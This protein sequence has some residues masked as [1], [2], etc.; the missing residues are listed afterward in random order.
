MLLRQNYTLSPLQLLFKLFQPGLLLLHLG[1]FLLVRFTSLLVGRFER[2]N[3]VGFANNVRFFPFDFELANDERDPRMLHQILNSWSPGRLK[4]DH[5]L[6]DLEDFIGV[7]RGDT[8]D[9]T[10]LNLV[11][12][13]D[14]I[15]RLEGR[16][17]GEHLVDHAAGRPDIRLLVVPLLLDLLGAHVVRRADVRVGEDGFVAHDPTQPKITQL[18]VVIGVEEDV[19]G[20]QISMQDL[21]SLFPHVA[22]EQSER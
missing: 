8:I 2:G 5:L 10:E 11:G 15:G 4:R 14:L 12:E 20:L 1:Q 22:L 18:H 9:L 6:D 7:V 17:Q 13:L 19:S 21:V 16:P 3:F